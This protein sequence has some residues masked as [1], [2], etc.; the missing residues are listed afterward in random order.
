MSPRRA[1]PTPDAPPQA[2]R[3][4]LDDP[5]EPLYTVA[6]AA[7]LLGL[8]PQALR[9]LGDALDHEGRRPSGNQR[10]YSRNDLEL[11]SRAQELLGD[12][13]AT[14]SIPRIMELERQV[15]RLGE[16]VTPR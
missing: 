14:A 9:R 8:D 4:R 12:G 11:L 15:G 7:D 13:H 5:D 16:R 2:W 3:A 1:A 6:V 10:R